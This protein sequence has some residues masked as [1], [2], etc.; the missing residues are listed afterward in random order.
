[1]KRNA[2][3]HLS[4][5][6]LLLMLSAL[7]LCVRASAEPEETLPSRS[8]LK[9]EDGARFYTVEGTDYLLYLDDE[10]DLL[11]SREEEMLLD[12]M[13]P[14]TAYGNAAFISTGF[15]NRN[16]M[17]TAKKM[18]H[19]LFGEKSGTVF[20]IDMNN[21]QLI[22]HSDGAVYKVISK[23]YANTITDNVY[24]MA[25]AGKYYDCAAEVFSEMTSLLQGNHIAQPM[26]HIT[27]A[28]LAFILSSMILYFLTGYS[29]RQKPA[30]SEEI[31]TAI[32]AACAVK[33]VSGKLTA[34][35]KV[36]SPVSGKRGGFGGFGGG[37]GSFGGGGGGGS[38]GF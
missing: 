32:S 22:I 26:R 1:M 19:D 8:L 24:R 20:I 18:Y 17:Q 34:S 5:I 13:T 11:T 25:R 9:E 2:L 12:R 33:G 38:H 31:L 4:V 27:N 23:S 6:L 10:E 30:P 15:D 3:R 36:Y 35:N 14:V 37:G 7:P 21:R 16:Y 28:L 29:A